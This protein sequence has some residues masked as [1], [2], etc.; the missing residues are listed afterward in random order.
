[1]INEQSVPEVF[2]ITGDKVK[3]A[4]SLFNCGKADVS[5]G[6]QICYL[7]TLLKL[8]AVGAFMEL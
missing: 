3:E 5:E 1:M 7:N 4:A 8:S 6:G 2:K